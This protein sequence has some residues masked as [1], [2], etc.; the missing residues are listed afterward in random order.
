M[1]RDD[2][3]ADENR[4]TKPPAEPTPDETGAEREGTLQSLMG[5]AVEAASGP[6]RSVAGP[7]G[8]GVGRLAAGAQRAFRESAGQRVRRVRLMGHAPLPN[9]YS[10]HPAARNAF[11]RTLGLRTIPVTSIRGTAVEGPTQRGGD[12]L[13]L[14]QLRG[15]DWQGRWQRIRSALDQLVDLPPI[16]VVKFGDEYWVT[17]GHNRV[18]AALY[19]GQVASD[20]LV[21]ELRMP[22]AGSAPTGPVAPYLQGSL[23]LRAAGEGRLTRTATRPG[24]WEVLPDAVAGGRGGADAGDEQPGIGRPVDDPD[25][26]GHGHGRYTGPDRPRRATARDRESPEVDHDQAARPEDVG[27]S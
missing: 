9:L 18:A 20:A 2:P 23:D 16:E 6:V 3:M 26:R 19:N 25:Q 14:K 27:G 10:V 5:A 12:F 8:R 1:Q 11:P 24:D 13:P 15:L 7:I 22:G 4:S 17:D 21:T